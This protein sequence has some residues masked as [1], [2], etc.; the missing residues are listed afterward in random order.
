MSSS[1]STSAG[2][3][4]RDADDPRPGRGAA[5]R[6][7]PPRPVPRRVGD[8]RLPPAGPDPPAPGR[9]VPA[10]PV[11][12]PG[13]HGD[14]GARLRRRRVREPLPVA[15]GTSGDD[16][17]ATVRLVARRPGAG[18]CEVVCFTADH[19]ASFAAR[20]PERVAHGGGG[21]G[22]PHPRAVGAAT[23]SSRCSCFENRGEEIGVTLA[24]PHGQIYAYP[25][26]TP[27]TL[28]DARR[29]ARAPRDAPAVTC[30]HD[31]L[32]AELPTAIGSS[33]RTSTGWPSCPFAARWP[34]EV[35]LYPPPAC[36]TC[37]ALDDD[38]RD[39]LPPDLPRRAARRFD[40]LFD[41]PLP[42]ISAWHQA[43]VRTDR[44]LA[45]LHLRAVLDP[46]RSD[47][48][49]YLAGSR[50]R[51]GRLRQRRRPRAGGRDRCATRCRGD[52][53][54]DDHQ[55]R[56]RRDRTPA[57]PDGV[58]SAPGPGQ[59]DRRAHRLQRRLRAAVRPS[60]A[61]CG[62]RRRRP[63]TAR[64]GCAPCS[65]RRRD[66]GQ[67][68]ASSA[69]GRLDGWAAYAGRRGLGARRGRARASR[70]STSSSTG[71]VPRRRRAVLVA[72][73]ECA[74]ALALND[75]LGAG[76]GP[77]SPGASWPARGRERVRRGAVAGSWTRWRRCSRR[78]GHALFL[79]IRSL[80]TRAGP[81]GPGGHRA[82]AA[83]D[84]HPGRPRPGRRCLR[85]AAGGLRAAAGRPRR[86]GPAGR[87]PDAGRG[88]A[89][90][91][92]GRPASC[93]R[94]RHVVTENA[95]VAG[96]RGAA[97]GR[98]PG[99]GWARCW[100]P[101]TRSLRDDYEVSSPSSTSPSTRPSTPARPG[102]A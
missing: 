11:A 95:R 49:K 48:L 35:H 7:D 60:T 26:V 57:R 29:G 33:P 98:R 31:V 101:P 86:A 15:A 53:A 14:P 22:R 82:G 41:R 27:R 55:R 68:A 44:D 10:V 89:A 72:A 42:Y 13:T 90:E 28:A 21:L 84:R 32:A 81:A 76:P 75:L 1:T 73:L 83:G 2:D 52:V 70:G 93:A 39:G 51:H 19:D 24:H 88:R 99:R 38:E 8:R 102:R 9:R 17:G 23:V 3:A 65:S 46:P 79:D 36:P 69:P 78:A 80:E 45:A 34:F 50:V 6:R 66:R 16:A 18:R 37:P 30:S 62:R 40:R 71:D 12:T 91:A 58:W 64:C 74:V 4:A 54:P 59:P 61:R 56:L 47:K 85:R 77:P 87:H 5:P 96:G 67:L 92:L 25:F 100:P 63:T 43:P 97:A 94:V 20:R